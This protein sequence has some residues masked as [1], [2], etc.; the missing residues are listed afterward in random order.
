[1]PSTIFECV[2]ALQVQLEHLFDLSEGDS[3]EA[4]TLRD[5]LDPLWTQL[6]PQEQSN[7]GPMLDKWPRV[8]PDDPG[9]RP[10]GKPD[11]CFYCGQRVG[12]LHQHDCIMVRKLVELSVTVNT[13]DGRTLH[14]SFQELLPYSWDASQVDFYKNEGSWCASNYLSHRGPTTWDE[15]PAAWQEWLATVDA[16]SCLCADLDFAFVRVM[17]YTPQRSS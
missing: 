14:G 4:E 6:T 5:R 1:M 13:S 9:I 11:Q 17:D 8:L 15:G 16:E 12:F 7:V 2:M 10:A 3:P